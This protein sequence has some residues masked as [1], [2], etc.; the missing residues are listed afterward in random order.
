MYN[1]NI[2]N[3]GKK[4]SQWV[5]VTDDQK[6]S[7]ILYK[8]KTAFSLFFIY[9]YFQLFLIIANTL[10]LIKIAHLESFIL[11]VPIF[12][13]LWFL[14]NS[15]GK[16]KKT[17]KYFILLLILFPL[18]NLISSCIFALFNSNPRIN[19]NFVSI[20][21]KST[22]MFVQYSIF[23]IIFYIYTIFSEPFNLQYLN[24]IKSPFS[25]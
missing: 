3:W 1:N 25:S 8:K 11:L 20:V 16:N 15:G 10:P 6:S 5:L 4:M 24:R 23:G 21:E 9:L 2:K 17:V 13:I 14:K 22:L 12:V 19:F 18:S 7:H